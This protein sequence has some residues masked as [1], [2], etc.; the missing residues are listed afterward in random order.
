M[1]ERK[2]AN[3]PA[4]SA[5]DKK[6]WKAYRVPIVIVLV[7]LA[8]VG[9]QVGAQRGI[10]GDP[11]GGCPG[12]WHYMLDVHID[13]EELTFDPQVN[14]AFSEAREGFH[15]HD[16]TGRV[17]MHPGT[18]RC[19]EF[20]ETTEFFG[21][22]VAGDSLTV[23]SSFSYRTTESVAGTYTNN[24]THEVRLYH[25]EWDYGAGDRGAWKR[26][27]NI[28][29]FLDDQ[30]GNGDAV[31]LT[32]VAKDAPDSLIE[33]QQDGVGFIGDEYLPAKKGIFVP[34]MAA[35]MFAGIGLAVWN[36]FRVA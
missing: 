7:W 30:I 5:G 16:A 19:I 32:Y 23:S 18:E 2:R 10:V 3:A 28:N 4:Q 17:H 12:H 33:A 35:T 31:L 9:Y 34:I 26:V 11:G 20:Q 22:D 25:A 13:D 8:I 29:G 21:L 15:I 14:R 36:K 27:S 1:S 24:D 6:S